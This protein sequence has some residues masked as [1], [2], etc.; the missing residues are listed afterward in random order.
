MNDAARGAG[1]H[2]AHA[3]RLWASDLI[4]VVCAT[5]AAEIA[6]AVA[7]PVRD[8]LRPDDRLGVPVHALVAVALVLLWMC[9]LA[10]RDTRGE[11]IVG[12]G[13]TELRRVAQAGFGV[14]AVLCMVALSLQLDLARGQLLLGLPLALA[15][16]C[17]ERVLWRR[18]LNRRRAAGECAARVLLVGSAASVTRIARALA[19]RPQAGYRVVAACVPAGA[20]EQVADAGIP[21]VGG[22]DAVAPGL[23]ASGADTVALTD[24]LTVSEIQRVAAELGPRDRLLVLATSIAGV[25]G[26]GVRVRRV[27]E[28]PLVRVDPPRRARARGAQPR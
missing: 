1:W 20:S 11:D 2:R 18:W 17:L 14:Y 13:A 5:A 16:V 26:P 21:I 3:R 4:A 22:L 6:L 9:A 25:P 7:G 24:E 8:A 19:R 15:A 10:L 28:L 23:D 27:P 12:H